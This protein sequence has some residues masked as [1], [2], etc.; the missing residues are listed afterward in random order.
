LIESNSNEDEIRKA[1]KRLSFTYFID[2]FLFKSPPDNGKIKLFS[3]QKKIENNGSIAV[4]YKN[5]SKKIDSQQIV[6]T[7]ADVYTKHRKVKLENP[8]VEL[9]SLI[10]DS[11]IY[12]GI[13]LFEIDRS[14]FEK[15]K[16]QFRPF[17]S[18][19][20]LHPRIAR[21]LVNLSN[22]KKGGVLLDP[23]CGTGGI[24]LE[25]GLIGAKVIGSDI[26]NKMING[27]KKNLDYY[28]IKDYNLFCSDIGE[29]HNNISSVDAIVTD[30]PYGKSTT[31]KGEDM[32]DLYFRAFKN[33][34]RALKKGGRAVI[35]ISKKDLIKIGEQY[36]SLIETHEFRT[37][38]SLTRYFVIFE[39]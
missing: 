4:K 18:P 19:I 1:S 38:R 15:R 14:D 20:S 13:K 31:T 17:F 23:F 16:V 35:G 28:N 21:V 6:K 12:V 5:R 8:D 32:K 37:H 24:L 30:F 39:K 34:S 3:L 9:R 11:Q 22:I 26:E 25:A 27:C 2:E 29:I 10:T 36:L 33:I 7:L